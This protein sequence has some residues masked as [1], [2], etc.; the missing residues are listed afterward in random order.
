MAHIVISC[1]NEWKKE[2]SF[3]HTHCHTSFI[4]A[5]IRAFVTYIFVWVFF[6][7]FFFLQYSV[8]TVYWILLLSNMTTRGKKALKAA[9]L[10]LHSFIPEKHHHWNALCASGDGMLVND[11]RYLVLVLPSKS[12]CHLF[13]I[14]ATSWHEASK[15][16]SSF[17]KSLYNF[18]SHKPR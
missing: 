3:R 15:N 13:S 14:P 1:E 9:S 18:R 17:L 7:S 8:S 5:V 16:T 11:D 4:L 10:L 6:F 12:K 2:N